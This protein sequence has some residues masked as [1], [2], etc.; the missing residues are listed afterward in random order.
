MELMDDAKRQAEGI[1]NKMNL[2]DEEF[3]YASAAGNAPFR[4]AVDQYAAA[5]AGAAAIRP[6]AAAAVAIGLIG[7]DTWEKNIPK[8]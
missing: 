5:M 1:L 8:I 4:Q 2:T 6:V 3:N 7:M